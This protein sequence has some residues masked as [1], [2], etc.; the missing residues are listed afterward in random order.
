MLQEGNLTVALT[1]SPGG[2]Q[3]HMEDHAWVEDTACTQDM[4]QRHQVTSCLDVA[5]RF[6]LSAP[7]NRWI[8]RTSA[9]VLAAALTIGLVKRERRCTLA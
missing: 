5:C 2:T 9:T 3:K 6:N 7:W 1:G 4:P 8:C